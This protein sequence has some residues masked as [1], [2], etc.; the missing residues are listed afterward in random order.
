MESRGTPIAVIG[1]GCR[2]PGGIDSPDAFWEALL[3]GEDLVTEIPA[4]RWD[5]EEHYDPERGVK[6][7]LLLVV[8]PAE[9][10]LP[11]FGRVRFEG[12]ESEGELLLSRVETIHDAYSERYRAHREGLTALVRSLG[13][14]FETLPLCDL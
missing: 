5:I 3:R 6:G 8:D 1:M 14:G 7:H 4:D 2:L 9:E 12:L 10:A 11:F 13:G